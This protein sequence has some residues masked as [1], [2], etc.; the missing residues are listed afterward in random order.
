M[1]LNIFNKFNIFDILY[2]L[3]GTYKKL[4]NITCDR[5][6]TQSIHLTPLSSNEKNNS[7][8]NATQSILFGHITRIYNNI[9]CFTVNACFLERIVHV[10]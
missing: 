6:I 3:I 1:H 4:D 8:T 7:N 9:E 5:T 2:S 10:N